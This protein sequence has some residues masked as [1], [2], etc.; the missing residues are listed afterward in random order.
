MDLEILFENIIV[1]S[2]GDNGE[3]LTGG[4]VDD[5]E[6]WIDKQLYS[7]CQATVLGSNSHARVQRGI[8]GHGMGVQGYQRPTPTPT[9]EYP[10]L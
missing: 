3:N 5:V 9:P 6:M 8:K 4:N 2:E 7:K 10:Y 1:R